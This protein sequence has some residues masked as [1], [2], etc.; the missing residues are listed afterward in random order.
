MFDHDGADAIQ[1]GPVDGTSS[2]QQVIGCLRRYLKRG[3][4][5]LDLGR[6][7]RVPGADFVTAARY[8]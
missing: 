3:D 5:L 6:P 2:A 4:Q 1:V 7:E 8:M